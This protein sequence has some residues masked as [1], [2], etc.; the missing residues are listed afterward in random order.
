MAFNINDFYSA[1]EFGGARPALFEVLVVWPGG[2]LPDF[3]FMCRASQIPAST[4]NIVEQTY[5]GRALK[6][7]GN[8]TF[9]DWPVTIINDE[10]YKIRDGFE[11]W[12]EALNSFEGN[13]RDGARVTTSSYKGTGTVRHFGKTGNLIREYEVRGLVPQDIAAMDMDW[14]TDEIQTFGVNFAMDY[15]VVNQTTQAA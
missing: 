3:N 6:F 15:W 10:D 12:S 4:L 5:F 8:R 13:I 14:G 7:A 9:A 11:R 1:L 2:Q